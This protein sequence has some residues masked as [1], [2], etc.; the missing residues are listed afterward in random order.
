MVQQVCVD[1]L[2][3]RQLRGVDLIQVRQQAAGHS[4][5]TR[6]ARRAFIVGQAVEAMIAQLGGIDR[7]QRQRL[8][9]IALCHPLIG[10]VGGGRAERQLGRQRDRQDQRQSQS[11]GN[12]KDAVRHR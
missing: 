6:T 1:L 8:I 2:G 4:D 9:H 12:G 3:P 10:L 5:H 11:A 7:I